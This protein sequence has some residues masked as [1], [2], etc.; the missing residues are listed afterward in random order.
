MASPLLEETQHE[1]ELHVAEAGLGVHVDVER[2][3][4]VVY[5]LLTNAAKYSNAR[6]RIVVQ[7]ALVEELVRDAQPF[8][9]VARATPWPPPRQ[10]TTQTGNR[11]G[12]CLRYKRPP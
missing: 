6:S 7:G 10:L 1:V 12:N 11:P 8:R 2:M 3:A 4:Q 9:G 5:N